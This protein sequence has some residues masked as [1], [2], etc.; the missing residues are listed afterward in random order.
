[1]KRGEQV[2]GKE[3][4]GFRDF[5]AEGRGF[6]LNGERVYLRGMVF[7]RSNFLGYKKVVID[8][9]AQC[10]RRL[11]LAYK[12]W[13]VNTVF[14]QSIGTVMPR[15]FYDLCDEL[16]ILVYDWPGCNPR[17]LGQGQNLRQWFYKRYNHPS[18]VMVAIGNENR[19][20]EYVEPIN[21]LYDRLK[22]IDKQG[23]PICAC[24]GNA[25]S[26][27]AF[28]TDVEDFHAYPGAISG[29]P[30]DMAELLKRFNE[31][32]WRFDGKDL[33]VVNWEMGGSRLRY[34]PR[35]LK[36]CREALAQEP[37]DKEAVIALIEGADPGYHMLL[38]VRWLS[39]YGIRR[40]IFGDYERAR[41]EGRAVE[42]YHQR[43]V[44]KGEVEDCR[45]SGDLIQGMGPN[46]YASDLFYLRQKGTTKVVKYSA[47]RLPDSAILTTEAYATF[48]RTYSPQ[49]V[50][51]DVFDRNVF[52]GRR[53]ETTVYA[54][55]DTPSVSR[56]W[57]VR[58]VI[59]GLDGNRL[60][61]QTARIGKVESFK[62]KLVP[63]AWD[64]PGDART[65]FYRIET[66][67]L[68]RGKV[69]SDNHY[70]FFVLSQADLE[71]T[72]PTRGKKVALYDVSRAAMS[73]KK[74]LDDLA[75]EYTKIGSLD[76]LADYEVLIIGANSVDNQVHRA[77][78][79][80]GK[81]LRNG[82]RLLQYEQASPGRI[83]YVPQLHIVKK[84]GGTI[85]DMIEISHPIFDK[86]RAYDNWDR[87]SG[88]L[89]DAHAYGR[90]GG[91]YSGLIGPLNQ[92]VLATGVMATPRAS[93]KAVQM[94]ISGVK[95]GKGVALISQAEATRRYQRDSVATKY[96]RNTLKYILSDETRYARSVSSLRIGNVDFR[97]C[98]YVDLAQQADRELGELGKD[99]ATK[100][101]QGIKSCGGLRFRLLGKGLLVS[102]KKTIDLAAT[103]KL[104]APEWEAEKRK[105][106]TDQLGLQLKRQEAVFFLYTALEM[107]K[108][109]RMGEYTF[110]YQDG[111]R[112]TEEIR[113]GVNI[114][115]QQETEDLEN[116][117]YVGEGF[118]VTRWMNPHQEKSLIGLEVRA[119][120][121]KGQ[122]LIAG[123]TSYLIRE[124]V[125]W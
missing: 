85:A 98:G 82:G 74:V 57:S 1:M 71:E 77:G 72:I 108:G 55:N 75:L 123:I 121:G 40:Y 106:D 2:I 28:K 23:R 101:T 25:P 46:I 64:I 48:K 21:A 118:Y 10:M 6:Y 58:V 125:H 9:E 5:R 30:L 22:K 16:G 113:V 67:L 79:T 35:G 70:K 78:E 73:T 81:W 33:P 41:R 8:N 53:L 90:C 83:S 43:F 24:S 96:L 50:C 93:D 37:V 95:V 88:T 68:E 49:F 20:R 61:D 99:W 4:F 3:R 13:H 97:R 69:I 7:G 29:H 117:R 60:S 47:A 17:V 91:I 39:I 19:H 36:P 51:L 18:V 62:R 100:I 34:E 54:I 80:I 92:T 105:K 86:V 114:G 12:T 89:P 26:Q 63:H 119:E 120:K 76:R 112:V 111:T 44:V 45:R 42:T 59:R 56:S 65:G 31:N 103:M 15:R 107:Q 124:K 11:L 87:W 84:Y 115:G 104:M 14:P 122:V 38:N 110:V 66:F 94:L 109:E 116:A 102:E 52:A 32:V 27:S